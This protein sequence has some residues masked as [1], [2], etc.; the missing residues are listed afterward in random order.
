MSDTP[1]NLLPQIDAA[2]AQKHVT[3]NEAL[4][5][6]D[7][8]LN[9]S[10]LDRDLAA[11]PGSPAQGDSYI[12]A[13]APTGLWAGQAGKLAYFIDTAWRFYAP[14]RGQ[15]IYVVD[16]AVEFVWNGSAWTSL[17]GQA[18]V[19]FK[20][21]GA[22]LGTTGTV[23]SIDFTGAGVTATRATNA[24]TVNIP[25]GGGSPGGTSSQIQYNNAGAFGG[26]TMSGDA[27]ITTGGVITIAA[28]AVG[29][30]K[31]ADIATA[32]IMGRNT[33]ATGDPEVLSTSTVKTML[34]LNTTDN[35]T[36]GNVTMSNLTVNGTTFTVNSTITT[37]DDP[38]LTLGGDTAP[39]SDDGK[40]RGIEYRWHNA[41]VAKLG[42]FGWDR[43]LQQFTFI[44]DATN[45]AEVMSGA[46]GAI[47]ADVQADKI[48]INTAPDGTNKLAVTSAASLFNNEGAGVQVKLNKNAAGDTASFLFQTG[49]SGRAEIGTIADNNFR[50][51]V[52]N[53]GTTFFESFIITATSGLVTVKNGIV[54]DPQASDP[55]S[56]VAG[57]P[58]YNSTD[59]KFKGR[60]A[61]STV[62]FALLEVAQTFSAGAKQT[63]TASATTAG[64]NVA[65]VAGDPSV[66]VDGDLWY[67]ATTTKFRV[68]ENG[69]VKD[70]DTGGGVSDGDKGDVI[71]SA[72]GTVWVLDAA[73]HIG[74]ML[75]LQN[76]IFM[77]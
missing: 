24:L 66:V 34:G 43:S 48:G 27:T 18:S 21:E 65:P 68:K 57:Q 8:L 52:S 67:N 62:T 58:W 6:L 7:A 22:N 50:F 37:L 49:F 54:L 60:L 10:V 1:R 23:T 16:E 36:F 38:L 72:S 45:T 26:Y 31:L 46:I 19:Q 5:I 64:L 25:S 44:P 40:D 55:A 71:V 13:A 33:A 2:Q 3:H 12:V 39:A 17:G 41:T 14:V 77:N 75:A 9:G 28:N 70:M 69:T 73:A 35:P 63:V 59:A 47:R 30:T 15:L 42:F 53:D 20:D 11:P 4:V 32:S 61:A 56:P 74:R 29:L 76:N 51:K